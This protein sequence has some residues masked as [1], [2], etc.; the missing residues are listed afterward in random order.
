MRA[1]EVV[2]LVLL[3]LRVL[4]RLMLKVYRLPPLLR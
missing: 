3:F 2:N 4:G 1:L